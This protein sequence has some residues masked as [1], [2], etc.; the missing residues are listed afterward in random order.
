MMQ[1]FGAIMQTFRGGSIWGDWWQPVVTIIAIV[2]GIIGYIYLRKYLNLH[3]PLKTEYSIQWALEGVVLHRITLLILIRDALIHI[4][5]VLYMIC[6]VYVVLNSFSAFAYCGQGYLE[7][8][9]I[10]EGFLGQLILLPI[11]LRLV[12]EVLYLIIFKLGKY[13]IKFIVWVAKGIWFVICKFAKLVYLTVQAAYRFCVW[14]N[15]KF[16]WEAIRYTFG[17]PVTF[18]KWL[19][20][21]LEKQITRRELE[22]EDLKKAHNA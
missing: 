20:A 12:Y 21:L 1:F 19:T 5:G 14:F 3:S 4:L 17:L 8:T 22:T 11:A 10:I 15:T 9:T 13:I 18:F 6:T 2:A 16:V 7:V